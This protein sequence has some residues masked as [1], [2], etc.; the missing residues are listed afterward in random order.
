MPITLDISHLYIFDANL[1]RLL[2]LSF[3]F[4]LVIQAETEG[5]TPTE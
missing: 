2:I 1:M 3:L 5:H 4:V